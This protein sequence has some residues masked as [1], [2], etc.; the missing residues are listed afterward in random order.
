MK[1]HSIITSLVLLGTLCFVALSGFVLWFAART[2]ESEITR[3]NRRDYGERIRNKE[4]EYDVVDAISMASDEVWQAQEELIS[5]LRDRY[6]RAGSDEAGDRSASPF[7]VNGDG[8]IILYVEGSP[9][10][11]SFFTADTINRM[12][13]E[14]EGSATFDAEGRAIWIAF[15]YYEPWDW[16]TGYV[17]SNET[18][19]AAVR[20][21][22]TSLIIAVV[23]GLIV[24]AVLFWAYVRR[25][26]SPLS[27]LSRAMD[28][29]TDG[30]L[31]ARVGTR[32]NNE[33][34]AISGR[35][36]DFAERLS[37]IIETIG[38]A[39]RRNREVSDRLQSHSSQSLEA[40]EQI[41]SRAAG[42]QEAMG[43]LNERA[44]RS[45]ER[46]EEVRGQ[47]GDL[48]AAVD[49]Q[50]AAVTQSTAA[51]EQMSASL[52]NVARITREK[53]ESSARLRETVREGSEKLATT[54]E[55][56]TDVNNRIDDI[57][58]LLSII[59]NIAAQTDLLSMNAAIEA[60]HAGEAGRGFAVVAEEI[61]KLA[62]ESSENST[63]IS[64]IIG[65]VIERIRSIAE[66]SAQTGRAFESVEQEVA[67]VA[68]SFQEIAASADELAS[69][70]TEIR[71][72]MSSLKD[73][74]SRVKD[75]TDASRAAAEE[76]VAALTDID[77]RASEVLEGISQVTTGSEG[78]V[79][80]VRR[81][82]EEVETLR[83]SV[84]ELNRTIRG[85]EA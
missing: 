18:R 28:E 52:D 59:Q 27:G 29:L 69:G 44:E 73:V 43:A 34:T 65:A 75:G 4:Y 23:G 22:A 66:A 26:L 56:V 11:P 32:G 71:T 53:R 57:S 51:A 72:S 49:E 81:I 21:F 79:E 14:G 58:N 9:V 30:N 36:N 24:I 54:R 8:D 50:F 62:E 74:S 31:Q 16:V 35:F 64:Q 39:A 78:S 46:M 5:G 70:S 84:A 6:L 41:R 47:V 17:A 40:A 55:I 3:L 15:S 37:A 13:T 80:A 25:S 1:R 82:T 76:I 48:T 10:E 60:A 33:I 42:M 63:S 7:I 12:I 67:E 38:E 45:R 85:F 68:D 20:S 61:R 83:S 2:F 77:R 19:L